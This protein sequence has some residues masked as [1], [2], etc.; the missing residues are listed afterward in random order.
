MFEFEITAADECRVLSRL[1]H[2]DY[3]DCCEVTDAETV[4]FNFSFT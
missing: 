2:S 1:Y 4:G 3:E